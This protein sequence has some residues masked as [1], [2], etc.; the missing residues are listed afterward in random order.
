MNEQKNNMELQLEDA[1]TVSNNGQ[2]QVISAESKKEIEKFTA[3]MEKARLVKKEHREWA[4][5]LMLYMGFVNKI[6]YCSRILDQINNNGTKEQIDKS[7]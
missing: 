4:A 1:K 2:N 3:F 7:T 6:D 5:A